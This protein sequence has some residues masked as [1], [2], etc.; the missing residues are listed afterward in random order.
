MA[1][2]AGLLLLKLLDF[3]G[4]SGEEQKRVSEW[5][6]RQGAW[7]LQID[8]DAL[9]L[10]HKAALSFCRPLWR[11]V[12]GTTAFGCLFGVGLDWALST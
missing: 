11:S 4:A 2:R 10:F 7:D 12:G 6:Y 1:K 8:A 3:L 5:V 9:L